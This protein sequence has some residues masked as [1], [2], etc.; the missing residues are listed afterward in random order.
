MSEPQLEPIDSQ[1]KVSSEHSPWQ[2]SML[3][4]SLKDWIDKLGRVWVEGELAQ[5]NA[6]GGNLFAE[7]RDLQTEN[8]IAIHSWKGSGGEVASDLKQGD[9]VIA[10]IKPQFWAKN[11]R[12][13][14]QVYSIKKVGLGE[15][16]E[17]IEKLRAQLTLEGLTDPA[18]KKP[19]PFIPK[20]IGLITGAGSDA[21]KDVLENAKLRWP[22]VKFEVLN[23]LVQGER[24]ISEI[25]FA[26]QQLDQNPEVDVIIVARGGG[27]FQD[28]LIFSDESLVRAAA[29][30]SKPLVSAIGHENDRPLLDDVS[31]LRASTPTDAAKRVVPDVVE[32]RRKLSEY[33]NRLRLRLSSYLE[34][35]AQLIQSIRS[36][37]IMADPF[38]FINLAQENLLERRALLRERFG[39]RLEAASSQIKQLSAKTSS[40]SPQLTMQRGYAVVTD[41][42][43]KIIS[44]STDTK[45][46]EKVSI[47][48]LQAEI[49]ASVIEVRDIDG[50]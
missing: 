10:L 36:R 4:K 3:S 39:Y 6:R 15:I 11:G 49:A 46:G 48:V 22:E 37:P 34:N 50:R 20:T 45:S 19:L 30:L 28:L 27:S 8:T 2:V 42:S 12:L 14:M 38:G 13:S 17:R 1:S 23:T 24:A 43:G 41:A 33:R 31:D 32:E 26:M 21:E 7:L 44:A 18:K 5:I 47:R 40:L 35:Q 16:L 25:I 9:R 29:A